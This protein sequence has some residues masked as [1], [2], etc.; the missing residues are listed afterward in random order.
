MS[1]IVGQRV[2]FIEFNAGN[3]ELEM[4][5]AGSSVRILHGIM[6]LF[7]HDSEDGRVYLGISKDKQGDYDVFMAT[8]P[9]PGLENPPIP[10]C[11]YIQTGDKL[12][13]VWY[14]EKGV[15][16]C[17]DKPLI[18]FHSLC[19]SLFTRFQLEISKQCPVIGTYP[20]PEESK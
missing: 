14:I 10:N 6:R 20:Y 4:L 17:N 12:K 19:Y 1:P 16:F 18:K 15:L 2:G 7:Y 5:K 11:D 13:H 8:F 9:Y 3:H